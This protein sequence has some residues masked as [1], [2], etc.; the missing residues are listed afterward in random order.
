M[1]YIPN[2]SEKI[3]QVHITRVPNSAP[4]NDHAE[5]EE[6][7]KNNGGKRQNG[8]RRLK[9]SDQNTAAKKVLY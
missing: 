4:K 2:E 7:T 5:V 8:W 3:H 1:F 6:L 9:M